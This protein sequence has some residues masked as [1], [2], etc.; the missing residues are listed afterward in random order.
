MVHI[1]HECHIVA[2][3]FLTHATRQVASSLAILS[4]SEIRENPVLAETMKKNSISLQALGSI[5]TSNFPGVTSDCALL[6]RARSSA[7]S[8]TCLGSS[9]EISA[10]VDIANPVWFPLSASIVSEK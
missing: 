5:T 9:S 6:S 10:K 2:K 7:V 1:V 3:Y 8:E 4:H